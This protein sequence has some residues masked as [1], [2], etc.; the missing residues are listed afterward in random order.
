MLNT[1]NQAIPFLVFLCVTKMTTLQAETFLVTSLWGGLVWR[2]V[3]WLN[4][5]IV[6]LNNWISLPHI[7]WHCVGCT[8]AQAPE[9]GGGV[10]AHPP[11]LSTQGCN[12]PGESILANASAN[13]QAWSSCSYFMIELPISHPYTWTEL[14]PYLNTEPG[15]GICLSN[16]NNSRHWCSSACVGPSA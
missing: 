3:F 15:E 4:E 11:L 8:E 5:M 12:Y 14:L 13:L 2:L 6:V 1:S 7:Y 10:C 9:L 16:A